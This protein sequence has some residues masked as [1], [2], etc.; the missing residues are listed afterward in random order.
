MFLR[1]QMDPNQPWLHLYRIPYEHGIFC[2]HQSS[3]RKYLRTSSLGNSIILVVRYIYSSDLSPKHGFGDL[4]NSL[5]NLSTYVRIHKLTNSYAAKLNANLL[6]DC[7]SDLINNILMTQYICMHAWLSFDPDGI[8]GSRHMS[9]SCSIKTCGTYCR[10]PTDGS[11]YGD[12]GMPML[13]VP[14]SL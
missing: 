13:A 10:L 3:A 7:D 2:V 8:K 5:Q 4:S 1:K 6:C 14:I 9:V 12:V 11:R